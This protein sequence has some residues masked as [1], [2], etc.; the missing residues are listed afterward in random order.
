MN[1]DYS[2]S[3]LKWKRW[4][5][6]TFGNLKKNN[7]VYFST[8]ISRLKD[9]LPKTVKVLEIGFGNGSFLTFARTRGWDIS[10]TEVNRE[11]IEIAKQNGFDVY[12][13]EDLTCFSDKTFDLIVAFDVL[14][15]IPQSV[16]ESFIFQV[17]RVLKDGGFFVA[18][19]PN[20]DSPFG[21]KV[22]NGDMTHVTT[23]GSGKIFYLGAKTNMDVVFLGGRAEPII[24]MTGLPL[25][26]RI[27]SL[28]I[29]KTLNLIIKLIFF[30]LNDVVFCS[31]ELTA[32][33]YK[34]AKAH[35]D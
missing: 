33:Y 34:A 27:I 21:L 24:G 35:H 23:I 25:L 26:H 11:L 1:K 29:K 30:P 7:S 20:G 22:Q 31:S 4:D 17:K 32:I 15:H 2:N 14:E 5:E 18:R 13:S 9:K 10:G 16:L 28:P 8:E 3:Y 12:E 19:F 6:Q